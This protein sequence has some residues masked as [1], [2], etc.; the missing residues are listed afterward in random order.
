MVEAN[1]RPVAKIRVSTRV[2][3]ENE[4]REIS[5]KYG[6][7][8]FL[9]D[10]ETLR[11]K[12]RELEEAFSGFRGPIRIAYSMKANFNPAVVKVFVSEGILFDITSLGELYFYS[13]CGGAP[14]NAIYTSVTEEEQEFFQ[15][16]QAGVSRIVVGSYN[17]L[18]NLINASER[19][20]KS[21]RILARVNP[22]VAVKAGIR[23]SYRHGK[24]GVPFNSGTTDSAHHLVRKIMDNPRL[25]FE[26]FHFH[27]GSQVVDP[28]CFLSAL[29]KL[30]IFIH[31]M[32]R[33]YPDINVKVIDIG[34][35]T[36]VVYDEPVPTPREIGTMLMPRLN[37]LAQRLNSNPTVILES[38]RYLSAE[39]CVLVSKIVNAKTYGDQKLIFVD[40]GYHLLLDAAL[41]RQEYPQEVYPKG[42]Y[43]PES[44]I[45]VAGRLCDTYDIF[46]SSQ[47][48]NL[49]GASVG[50]FLAFRNV[51]AYS[52]VFN[53]P[54]HCQTKPAIV[55]RRMNGDF[56]LVRQAQTIEDLYR[57]E[58]GELEITF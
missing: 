48:S 1:S 39:S 27:L 46:P 25:I 17:G 50:K 18:I 21:P 2:F 34:G 33:E 47:L 4:I 29:D 43:E 41:L 13:R 57:E 22:E 15:I 53:M 9:I 26:G 20:Q 42:R 8:V 23:A 11:R 51:G 58:G 56:V 7:P 14:E 45:T 19:A 32:S 37:Q 36:P 3:S 31:R 12:V 6:T 38:G 30:E 24:F 44:R 10:E 5:Q 54:F 49:D 52:I 16:L 28:Q 40:A 55:M 35:G